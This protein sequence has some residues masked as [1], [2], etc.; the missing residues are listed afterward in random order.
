MKRLVPIPIFAITIFALLDCHCFSQNDRLTPDQALEQFTVA[1]GLQVTTFAAD[2]EIVS[3]SNIDIDHRGRVWACECINYRGNRGKRPAGDRILIL[4]DTTGDGRSDKT[5]VFYQGT[6]VDVAMGLCVLGN[7]AIIAASPNIIL[8]EDTDGDDRADK[9]TVLLTSDAE[10]QH[11]HS[12]HSLVFGP[13]GRFYGNF[14][15]TGHRLKDAHGKTIVDRFGNE[16]ADLGKPYWG[17]M[18]FR[19]DREFTKFEVLGHNFRNNYE[20]TVDSFGGVW[21]SDNDDDGNLAVRLNYILEGGNYGY[22]DQLTGERWRAQRIGEHSFKG[23]RHWHQNDPG[24]VPNVIETGNGAPTGVTVYEG[25]LLAAS[26]RNQVIFCE[27][28]GHLVWS[29]PASASGA[30]FSVEKIEILHSTDNNFRPID[31][32]VAPDGSLLVSDWYDPVIGGFRQNDIERGRIYWIAPKGRRYVT[33]KYD[34]DSAAGAASALHSP[35]YCVRYLAWLRLHELG[36][37]AEAPLAKMFKDKNPRMRARALWLLGQIPGKQAKYIELAIADRHPEVRI[38][39]LRLSDLVNH[40]TLRIIDA[41]SEDLSPRVQAECVVHLRKYRSAKLWA[42]FANL[43]NGEDRWLLEALGIGADGNWDA[44]MAEY[45]NLQEGLNPLDDKQLLAAK[46]DLVWRSRGL[47]T[48]MALADIILNAQDGE[49]LRRY[50]RAFDFLPRSKYKDNALLSIAFG[51]QV[52][53]EIAMEAAMRVPAEKL[54]ANDRNRQKLG[55]LLSSGT[56]GEKSI[57]LIK[58]LKLRESY[59]WLLEIAQQT[60]GEQRVDAISTLLDLGQQELI[61]TALE[62]NDSVLATATGRVLAQSQNPAASVLLWPFI[63]NQKFDSRTRK[64]VARELGRSKYGANQF[65]DRIARGE[66]EEEL[67]QAVAGVLLVHLDKKVRVRAEE[68]FQLAPTKDAQPLPG[69]KQ[70][71]ALKGDAKAGREVF[72]KRGQCAVCHRIGDEGKMVGPDLSHIGTKLARTALFEA[73]LYPSAAI[74]HDYEN[75]IAK[76]AGGG[77]VI[78]VL[79]NQSDREIQLRDSLG[80]L[81]T[82]ERARVISFDRLPISLMPAN[83]HQLMTTQELVDL[84]D[85]LA[86]LKVDQKTSDRK[87]DG[88]TGAEL[89]AEGK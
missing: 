34:L 40:E 56:P 76:L 83:L 80:N 59:P 17:G 67:N 1:D 88:K 46:N 44:C 11:D 65:L 47:D 74:S 77:S 35:N 7:K 38:V 2:P 85:Y 89:K 10:F 58:Q 18:V 84:V 61:R 37:K 25:D 33:P 53:R 16:I 20:A 26:M 36:E 63:Q 52:S 15:N 24:T 79:V 51:K 86:D 48:P 12:L 43:Y 50:I 22:L 41:L 81:Q 28:G 55:A 60:Q 9:K 6:D 32:A 30:G 69:L 70:L 19:C 87:H 45:A 14:G 82:L 13:D 68:Q 57:P 78:G 62:S 4:E 72:S 54:G 39:G 73:I 3:I 71:A 75:Y 8:L 64:E 42:R 5:T 66:L 29:L 21:Q 49:D 31:V 23:K 27:A